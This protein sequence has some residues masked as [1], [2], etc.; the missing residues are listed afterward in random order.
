MFEACQLIG[1]QL[2]R[3]LATLG[4]NVAHALPA[5]DGTIALLA[6]DAQV[7]V[8]NQEGYKKFPLLDIFRGVGVS[9]L[10]PQKDL[11]TGFLVPK[12]KLNE[13]SAFSRVM[14]QQGIGLP[15][16]NTAVWIK[17][18][19]NVVEDIRISVGPAGPTPQR[20]SAAEKSLIGKNLTDENC[21]LALDVLL[22]Q[23]HFRTSPHRATKEYRV[24]LLKSVFKETIRRAWERTV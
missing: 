9:R 8:V 17:R 10:E 12:K 15:I 14:R 24:H 11:I 18:Q 2:V 4:G 13:S 22:E 16:L 7:E 20:G 3:N 21:D 23:V 5:G 1:G 6:L 19:K